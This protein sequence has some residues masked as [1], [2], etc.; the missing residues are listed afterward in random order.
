MHDADWD[1]LRAALEDQDWSPLHTL[2]ADSGAELL[3]RT[4]LSHARDCIPVASTLQKNSSHPWLNERV[5]RLVSARQQAAGTTD[6][7]QVAKSCSEGI[8]EEFHKWVKSM[9]EKISQLPRGS[10]QWRRNTQDLL[11]K[12][13]RVSNIPALKTNEGDWLRDSTAKA[14]RLAATLARKNIMQPAQLNAFSEM[15]NKGMYMQPSDMPT[16]GAA[17]CPGTLECVQ[18]SPDLLPTRIFRKCAAQLA[19]P[20]QLLA[21]RILKT[22]RWPEMRIQHWIVPCITERP[23]LMQQIT[24]AYILHHSCRRPWKDLS[25]PCSS[26]NLLLSL[27][28]SAPTSSHICQGKVPE[29]F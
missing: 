7:P 22:G 6:E 11:M 5:L 28:S 10:K 14:D 2:D 4:I 13:Q 27:S 17:Q 8:L 20:L 29:M 23:C 26:P 21:C 1:R 3:T 19:S 15:A 16:I 9:R 25:A 24:E 18:C 12:S